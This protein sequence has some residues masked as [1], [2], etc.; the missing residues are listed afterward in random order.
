MMGFLGIES[1]V[2]GLPS[3]MGHSGGLKLSSFPFSPQLRACSICPG[4][5]E[6]SAQ[7]GTSCWNMGLVGHSKEGNVSSLSHDTVF[8]VKTNS[9][10]SE[11]RARLKT[12][13]LAFRLKQD[14]R[15]NIISCP[16]QVSYKT[17]DRH[18]AQLFAIQGVL[19]E[20][21]ETSH[22]LHE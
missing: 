6:T 12:L 5:L 8:Y 2:P 16:S 4:I 19:A 17:Q 9:D 20:I 22:L 15:K 1:H 14:F 11:R 10:I 7:P 13:K 21:L 3:S 18:G